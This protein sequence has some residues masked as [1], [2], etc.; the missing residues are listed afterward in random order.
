VILSSTIA[1]PSTILLKKASDSARGEFFSEINV[2]FD[3]NDDD[4]DD[5]DD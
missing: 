1:I 5:D 2:L 3:D 4:N